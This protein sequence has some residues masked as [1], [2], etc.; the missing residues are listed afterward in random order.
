MTLLLLNTQH[1]LLHISF[2]LRLKALAMICN[3]QIILV[4]YCSFTRLKY[5]N[6]VFFSSQ[7]NA[8]IQIRS[9]KWSQSG[10]GKNNEAGVGCRRS[11]TQYSFI[12]KAN[13]VFHLNPIQRCEVLVLHL[14]YYMRTL[15]EENSNQRKAQ[16]EG[17]CCANVL[18]IITIYALSS[19]Q[20]KLVLHSS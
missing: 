10:L 16:L 5:Q 20:A 9:N 12:A 18:K 3:T 8:H 6:V 13:L 7:E 19:G 1:T 11:R 14:Y 2:P 17:K 4:H 15:Y